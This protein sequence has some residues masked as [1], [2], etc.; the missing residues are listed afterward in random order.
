MTLKEM[1]LKKAGDKHLRCEI[2]VEAY[3]LI[4][5][6]AE[7]VD[8]LDCYCLTN[9]TCSPCEYKERLKQKLEELLKLKT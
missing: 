5:A 2:D 7:A 4:E 8:W 9:V 6:L 1:I 3:R